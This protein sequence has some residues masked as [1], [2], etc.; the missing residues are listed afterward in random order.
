MP[1]R[2]I[3]NQLLLLSH[4]RWAIPVLAALHRAGDGA[5]FITLRHQLGTGA[6]TLSATLQRLCEVRWVVRNPGYGHPMR[7]EYV[8][9]ESGAALAPWCDRI[10][11]LIKR[12]AIEETALRKWSLPVTWA[13]HRGCHRFSQ[14]QRALPRI[15]SR[16]L[17][18]SLR[19]LEDC[20]VVQRVVYD[21]YPPQVEYELGARGS[22]LAGC[23][24]C[25]PTVADA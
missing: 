8:L 12:L 20:H 7:P 22:R 24:R 17:A 4:R 18:L 15:T 3:P 13:L 9:T 6:S 1:T 21:D 25:L 10:H 23:L 19:Q 11:I 14:M 2:P 16:A 5:K